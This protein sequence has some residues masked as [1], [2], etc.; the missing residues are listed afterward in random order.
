M[1]S[2]RIPTAFIQDLLTRIDVVELIDTRVKLKKAGA[3]YV[4]CC[5]FHQE[6]TPSFT[7]SQSKQF[8]H[9]FGCGE[10]GNAISFLMN[11]DKMSFIEALECLADLAGVTIPKNHLPQSADSHQQLYDMLARATCYYQQVLQSNASDAIVARAYLEKRGIDAACISRYAIGYAKAGWDNLL[12]QVGRDNRTRAVLL[13]AGLMVQKEN[14]G[15]YDRFRERLMFPIRDRRGRTIG[16]GGRVLDDT[17][18]KYLNSPE[19]PTFQKGR[20]LYGLYEALKSQH[21]VTHLIVVEGYM[22]VIS[23]AMH[24]INHVVATLG[25]ATSAEHIHS[26]FRYVDHLFFCFDGDRA[27]RQAAWRAL[28]IALPIMQDGRQITFMFMPDGEDPDSYVRQHGQAAFIELQQQSPSLGEWLF[29]HLLEKVNTNSMEGVAKFSKEALPLIGLIPK[30]ILQNLLLDKLATLTRTTKAQLLQQLSL[31]RRRQA[32]PHHDKLNINQQARAHD[33]SKQA[34]AQRSPMRRLISLLIQYPT[35]EA[36]IENDILFAHDSAIPGLRLFTQ[37]ALTIRE[38]GL[39]NTGMILER[40]RDTPDYS[41]LT[42]LASYTFPL[43]QEECRGE[44]LDCIKY[45]QKELVSE[46][47]AR[48]MNKASFQGL[49][50]TEKALLKELLD[51][52][53]TV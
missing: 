9:C 25:T 8:Y 7:V 22:D 11:F 35:L 37:I 50:E 36:D 43:S 20:E 14:G 10:S 40:W 26:L 3:N 38:Q 32:A 19:T 12:K 53:Q 15:G 49:E 31:T 33:V 34:M 2:K 39:S 13:K 4:A 17:L 28:K 44:F 30:G 16:F 41:T 47:I 52:R 45:I 42:K 29:D 21:H 5:P 48:L 18:P 23:M 6:N 1:K 46:R 27:G 24:G 51:E